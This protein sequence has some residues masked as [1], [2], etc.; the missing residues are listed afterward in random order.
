MAL[1]VIPGV[2]RITLPWQDLTTSV[3][4]KPVNVINV[5]S[6]TG[7]VS[8]VGST[9]ATALQAH[10]SAMFDTLYSLLTLTNI[11]VLPLDG[12]SAKLDVPI[13]SPFGGGGGGGV[14]PQVA[15]V[16][17]LHTTFR[18]SRG[19]GRVYVGPM[20]EGQVGNG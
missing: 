13:T 20:G 11:E 16:V 7:T 4:V 17:S 15:T 2:F 5:Q 12:I 14:L 6:T 1:P 9:V 8:Q 3:G 10:G 18:G 19:R